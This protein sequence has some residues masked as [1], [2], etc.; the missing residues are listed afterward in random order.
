MKALIERIQAEGIHI[1]KGII[2]VDGFVNHQ[3]D[4]ALTTAIGAEFARRFAQAGVDVILDDRDKSA[5]VKFKDADLVGFP[6]QVIIGKKG[7]ET[8]SVEVK[9]RSADKPEFVKKQ[10]LLGTMEGDGS[11]TPKSI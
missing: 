4:P 9:P 2:K 7:M 1:G 11:P 3:L 5:G 10:N 6:F 8:G